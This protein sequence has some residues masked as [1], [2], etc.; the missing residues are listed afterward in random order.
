MKKFITLTAVLAAALTLSSC[1]CFKKMAKDPAAIQVSCTPEVLVLNNGKIA[2]D[3]SASIPADYFNKKA[4]LKVTPVLFFE[5]GAVAGE[6]LL[7]QGEKV[8]SNGMVVKTKEALSINRHVEFDYQ[9][10]M[11]A[12]ELKL[13]V[14]VKCKSGKCKEFT[15]INA[16]NGAILNKEQ[17]AVLAANDEA[18]YAL[19]SECGRQIAVGLNTLQK[20]IDFAVAMEP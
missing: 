12:C 2:A 6:T 15:L 17:L 18:A 11:D 19:K 3:I 1:D 16:N 10:A 5:G 4:A 13:L 9:P 20:D 8:A 7:L 14:E